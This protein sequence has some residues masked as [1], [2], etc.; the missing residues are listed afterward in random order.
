M[1]MPDVKQ[2]F[3]GFGTDVAF[4]TPAELGQFLQKEVDTI[5]GI[6][7]QVGAKID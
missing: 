7:K 4:S 5:A 6:V 2:K 3:H 1:A